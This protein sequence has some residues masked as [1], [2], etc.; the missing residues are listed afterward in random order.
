MSSPCILIC[1]ISLTYFY[2][3]NYYSEKVRLNQTCVCLE[4]RFMYPESGTCLSIGHKDNHHYK[5][6]KLYK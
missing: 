3:R 5:N 2:I 4:V 6:R 1:E